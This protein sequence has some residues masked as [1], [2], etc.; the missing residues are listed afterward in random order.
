MLKK[1]IQILVFMAIV[2]VVG[3]I[4]SQIYWLDKAFQ[5]QKTQLGLRNE[6]GEADEKR[7]NDRVVIALSSVAEEILSINDDPTE[8]FQAVK[9]IKPNFFTVAINDTVHP[10]LLESLLISEFGKRN[11]EEDFEYGVYDCFNDSIV[12]GN[13]VDFNP[14]STVV[15]QSNPP[16]IKLD[17]D[18]HYFSV[19]F[20]S[21][22]IFVPEQKEIP[23]GT[24]AFS[25]ILLS[26]VF[27]FFGF[28]VYLMIR[29]KRLSEMKSDFIN[30]MTHE[31][32]TPIST[33]SLSSEVLMN[34]E[35]VNNPERLKQYARII[36]NE[37][38]RLKT[39]V[40]KV[41]QLSALDNE[42]IQLKLEKL[43]LHDVI[44][45]ATDSIGLSV[46]ERGGQ[47]ECRLNAQ[48]FYVPG[49][50]VHITNVMYNLLDNANK[51]SP[52]VPQITIETSNENDKMVVSISDSGIG[53]SKDSIKYIFDKFYRVPT[54]NI[55]NVKGFGLG[56]YYVK[57]IIDAHKGKIIVD[58]KPG[59]GSRFVISLPLNSAA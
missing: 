55:H 48:N 37:N 34:D 25:S 31:L 51:Y 27:S 15:Q 42:N 9:Q 11:I 30:N 45:K 5:V 21:R 19:Y 23:Y 3:I 14:D 28:S 16:E 57:L 53:I 17:K 50:M 26:I 58:S 59:K 47:I 33:I 6:Q 12:Y 29:Q 43:D 36:F 32:K 8:L 22:D 13:F 49:D 18:G 2:S 40:E 7:F 56:L 41:L 44:R 46:Q 35:I 52:E 24:W 39:Q 10:Y 38:A 54:G 4:I 1:S 20:P